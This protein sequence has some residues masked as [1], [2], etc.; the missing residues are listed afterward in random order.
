VVN[1]KS[2]AGESDI[3]PLNDYVRIQDIMTDG[4]MSCGVVTDKRFESWLSFGD[5]VYFPKGKAMLARIN[6]VEV[7]FVKSTDLIFKVG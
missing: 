3:R 5:R 6:G 4:E 1:I 2:V 7:Y